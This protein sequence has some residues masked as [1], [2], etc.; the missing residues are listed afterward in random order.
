MTRIFSDIPT[1]NP[2]KIK[3]CHPQG[4][5]VLVAALA[6]A[7]Q[8]RRRAS[9]ASTLGLPLAVLNQGS[10]FARSGLKERSTVRSKPV[11]REGQ[12]ESDTISM[13]TKF[14]AA[15]SLSVSSLGFGCC[16]RRPS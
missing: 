3:G 14:M 2:S 4:Q 12:S 1:L 13:N 11:Q 15:R 9:A 7:E 8:R 6:K 5:Q 16:G 10:C